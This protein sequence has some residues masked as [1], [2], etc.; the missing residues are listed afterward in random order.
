MKH[1]KTNNVNESMNYIYLINNVIFLFLTNFAFANNHSDAINIEYEIYDNVVIWGCDY[2]NGQKG[3]K[4][5]ILSVTGGTGNYNIT[6]SG[7]S[8]TS[9]SN[10]RSGEGFTY[11]FT[12][13]D[14]NFG[15]I[16]FQVQ[17]D[18]G[19]TANM[20]PDFIASLSNLFYF[21][22]LTCNAPGKCTQSTITHTQANSDFVTSDVYQTSNRIVSSADMPN[23]NV[24]YLANNEISLGVGF[25]VKIVSNFTADIVEPCAI[26][27]E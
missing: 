3:M 19:A 2:F 5:N 17:D 24:S 10:I 16:G 12:Q 4:I 7:S 15:T 20:R 22:L 25:H 9:T 27:L 6:V 8:K 11:F 13:S 26:T 14:V 23:G 18:Q 1:Y 21:A